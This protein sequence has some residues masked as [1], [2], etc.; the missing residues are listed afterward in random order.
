MMTKTLYALLTLVV[1]SVSSWHAT[2]VAQTVT[3]PD[4]NLAAAIRI[5]LGLGSTD[6]ITRAD[7][8]DSNFTSLSVNNKE[9][10]DISGLEYA[11]SLLILELVQNENQ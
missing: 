10:A 2:V 7:L 4:A 3:F 9:V 6:P 11:T 5:R 8:A 1:F